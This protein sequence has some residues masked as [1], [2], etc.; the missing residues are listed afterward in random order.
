M[1]ALLLA[2]AVAGGACANPSI[3]SAS[4]QSVTQTGGLNHHTV[5]IVV[6]NLGTV[7]QPSNLLQSIDVLQ[8]DQKT[9]KIGLQPLAPGQ[10][11]KVTYSFDRSADAGA[12]TTLLTFILDMN[13]QSG[14]DV[15]CHAGNEMTTLTV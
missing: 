10:S 9:G 11:Q 5:S 8:D 2:A 14:G 13:G 15:D 3:I 7:K 4:V 6:R 1:L 12:A